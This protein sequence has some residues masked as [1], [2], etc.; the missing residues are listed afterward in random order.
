MPV[1]KMGNTTGGV[2]RK[3][4]A[5]AWCW[6]WE[7]FEM[8]MDTN[9][10]SRRKLENNLGIQI[11]FFFFFAFEKHLMT[12]H[13]LLNEA[14]AP[15]FQGHLWPGFNVAFH[16]SISLPHKAPPKTNASLMFKSHITS[17]FCSNMLH[18]SSCIFLSQETYPPCYKYLFTCLP[19]TWDRTIK[20]P[21]QLSRI[22]HIE[23]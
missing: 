7:A 17:W 19:P 8:L 4:R 1:N 16:I 6:P 2:K 3:G 10:K 5:W 14:Q 11:H 13:Q 15:Y 18:R 12:P 20:G 22:E 21:H 23:R 9:A